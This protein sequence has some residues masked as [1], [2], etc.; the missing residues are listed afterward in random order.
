MMKKKRSAKSPTKSL[1]RSS[2][3]NQWDTR[4]FILYADGRLVY[5]RERPSGKEK[6]DGALVC[7]KIG[8]CYIDK[9]EASDLVG[10]E[11]AVANSFYVT[12]PVFSRGEGGRAA[13]LLV[14]EKKD[15]HKWILS[16][17]EFKAIMLHG[18]DDGVPKEPSKRNLVEKE[19]EEEDVKIT[20]TPEGDVEEVLLEKDE[21][22]ATETPLDLTPPPVSTPWWSL[23]NC[24]RK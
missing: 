23:S 16:F 17:R 2:M 6:E 3:G 19:E 21:G 10:L 24:C 8:D 4:Y 9:A 5:H 22:D 7:T 12:V 13:M 11:G 15:F 18:V 14:T 1:L 20:V